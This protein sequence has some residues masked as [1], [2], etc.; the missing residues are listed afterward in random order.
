MHFPIQLERAATS[1]LRNVRPACPRGRQIPFKFLVGGMRDELF[2]RERHLCRV[3]L[4]R[5]EL[6]QQ[7][8]KNV[9]DGRLQE[10]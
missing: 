1:P 5:M 7:T 2:G 3:V 6:S 8:A 4:C 9:K 10:S